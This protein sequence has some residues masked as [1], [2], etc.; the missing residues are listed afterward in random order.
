MRRRGA[1]AVEVRRRPAFSLSTATCGGL[2]GWLGMA[3]GC[4]GPPPRLRVQAERDDVRFGVAAAEQNHP[5]AFGVARCGQKNAKSDLQVALPARYRP[6]YGQS[7][8]MLI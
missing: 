2:D 1:V 5:I 8:R 4:V 6:H 3:Q 7:K